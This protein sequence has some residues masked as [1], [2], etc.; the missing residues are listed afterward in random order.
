MSRVF[1][2]SSNR[3]TD[4]Y[5]V[6]P[7]G[8]AVVSGA[9]L[10]AGHQVRQYDCLVQGSGR[11]LQAA[12]AGFGPELLSISL[13]NIDDVNSLAGEQ[14][15][16]L[17]QVKDLVAA[18]RTV[19][20]GP[21]VVGGPG[22]T[23]MPEEIADFLDIDYAIVGEGE[24]LLPELAATLAAGGS[25]PRIIRST[26]PLAGHEFAT[27]LFDPELVPYYLQETGILNLQTKRGC[28][29]RCDY[30]S[31]P[32]LEGGQFRTREPRQ[33]VAEL[34]RIKREQEVGRVFFTDSIF[35]D[36][37]GNYLELAE[38]MLRRGVDLQWAAFFRPQG[39]G[40]QEL[41]LLKR[42]G[43]FALELGTDAA[44]DRTLAGLNKHLTFAEVLEVNR[45]CLA[46]RLPAAHFVIFGG[47]EEDESTLAEGLDNLDQLDLS[48][49]FAFSGVRIHPGTPMLR[50]AVAEGVISADTPLLEPVYY[51]SPRI[52]RERMEASIEE[53]F[54]GRPNRIFP[55]SEALK[56]ITIM[57]NFGFRGLL[58]DQL[59]RFPRQKE[60]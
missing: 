53:R 45:A 11:E 17:R 15:W 31:Y 57:K 34:L 16:Y 59:V 49:V 4:P 9:L 38:E 58:W 21:I 18:I 30:C 12:I 29:Y 46:E 2:L 20:T 40:R 43:L 3:C 24:R 35:N 5:P 39:L 19:Y 48:V 52:D 33:V 60:G 51:F 26:R 14:G 6:Y 7:L 13:R 56:R 47:P 22:L 50:R 28:A 27:P 8:M 55:P 44:S 42:A 10:A 37:Q 23:L 25:S 36:P 1:L 32:L 54:A 41:A